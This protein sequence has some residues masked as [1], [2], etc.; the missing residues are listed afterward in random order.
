[1][2]VE[3]PSGP[4]SRQARFP[5]L[6]LILAAAGAFVLQA[7][8]A[9]EA[10]PPGVP[11]LFH[12]DDHFCSM[13]YFERSGNLTE[14]V[15][16]G[17]AA[18]AMYIA[19]G[20][21]RTAG[22]ILQRVSAMLRALG[23]RNSAIVE[24]RRSIAALEKAG[25]APGI[26]V[27]TLGLALLKASGPVPAEGVADYDKALVMALSG[28]MRGPRRTILDAAPDLASRL[29]ASRAFES[30]FA[31]LG[32][33][34]SKCEEAGFTPA[35]EKLLLLWYETA[36]KAGKKADAEAAL[37]RFSDL[38][39]RREYPFGVAEALKLRGLL[40]I[41]PSEAGRREPLLSARTLFETELAMRE[42]MDDR[43]GTGWAC[44]NL[45]YVLMLLGEYST[46]G[47]HLARAEK[48]FRDLSLADGLSKA[49]HNQIDL[50]AKTGDN[51]LSG[52][53]GKALGEIR[54]LP[55]PRQEDVSFEPANK[56]LAYY[57]FL[58]SGDED[59][60][61]EIIMGEDSVT[62]RDAASGEEFKPIPLKCESVKVTVSCPA[63]MKWF[64][65]ASKD[66]AK[67]VFYVFGPRY[68]KYG[69]SLI[70][71]AKGDRAY[72]VRENRLVRPADGAQV[73]KGGD[74]TA[75]QAAGDAYPDLSGPAA[76]L[77]TM[78]E[79]LN[80]GASPGPGGGWVRDEKAW[81][82]FQDSL[83]DFVRLEIDEESFLG[84]AEKRTEVPVRVKPLEIRELKPFW[85]RLRY[86]YEPDAARTA[87]GREK[88]MELLEKQGL[89]GTHVAYAILEGSEWKVDFLAGRE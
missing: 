65:T 84:T 69:D 3:P 35:A 22:R 78:V 71:L 24:I 34:A 58:R 18:A 19:A 6:F 56:R 87:L 42:G 86:E 25:D 15:Y 89:S 39:K 48:T 81:Q 83:S 1:M 13:D 82:T 68:V 55:L 30:A 44:N 33:V 38:C 41:E 54:N 57:M 16:H 72:S 36:V 17:R 76:A 63:P 61:V 74:V 45:G 60:V 46:A 10:A 37:G 52:R 73:Q 32:G 26:A 49:L 14:A 40:L 66:V 7:A 29:A 12:A 11:G 64:E 5:S 2:R 21:C 43:P 85:V 80:R 9:E 75:K 53:A 79:S 31:F 8:G 51:A 20:E 70:F 47:V 77:A 67:S 4:V 62:F 23:L 28:G 27:S 88:A 50:A 59:P